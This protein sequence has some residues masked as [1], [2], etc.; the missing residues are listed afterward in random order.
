MKK[1]SKRS[2]ISDSDLSVSSGY[3]VMEIKEGEVWKMNLK[4]R[5]NGK[6]E[7]VSWMKYMREYAANKHS[8]KKVRIRKA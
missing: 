7:L 8:D 4:Q 1:Q 2:N 3:A 5:W 6:E